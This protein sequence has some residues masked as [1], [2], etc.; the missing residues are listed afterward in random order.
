MQQYLIHFALARGTHSDNILLRIVQ[1]FIPQ[2]QVKDIN[3]IAVLSNIKNSLRKVNEQ[4]FQELIL[5]VC[6]QLTN[7]PNTHF[8]ADHLQVLKLLTENGIN[9]TKYE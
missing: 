8:L 4:T 2:M 6:D 9:C 3:I 5:A 7:N 1:R